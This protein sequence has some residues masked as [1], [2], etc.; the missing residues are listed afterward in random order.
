MVRPGL[1]NF[2]CED[3]PD[4][5]FRFCRP[6]SVASAQLSFAKAAIDDMQMKGHGCINTNL[7]M[8]TEIWIEV[9]FHMAQIFFAPPNILHY[10]N[11]KTVLSS[12]LYK[13]HPVGK[14]W[15]ADYSFLIPPP[16]KNKKSKMRSNTGCI[17]S[18]P[19]HLCTSLF[20][21][22]HCPHS[23]LF[24]IL[25]DRACGRDERQSVKSAESVFWTFSLKKKKICVC[26]F[27][28]L[29]LLRICLNNT[30]IATETE[31]VPF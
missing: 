21:Q 18:H 3:Q 13:K 15:P 12:W 14:I 11:V 25:K 30:S 5:Y 20:T 2:F 1:A 6:I 9:N 29:T 22:S 24:R 26:G 31:R 27:A 23:G 7:F 10:I 4:K 16:L 19:K 17:N 28:L 8:K